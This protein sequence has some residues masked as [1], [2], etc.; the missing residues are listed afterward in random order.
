MPPGEPKAEAQND[1]PAF[2]LRRLPLIYAV[3]FIFCCF[4]S[5][6][7]IFAGFLSYTVS[8]ISI[9]GEKLIERSHRADD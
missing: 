8:Y 9:F 5:V 7:Q 4:F 2:F 1:K 6:L 3:D